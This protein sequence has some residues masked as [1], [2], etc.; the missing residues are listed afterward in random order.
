MVWIQPI[1]VIPLGYHCMALCTCTQL[2]EPMQMLIKLHERAPFCIWRNP[3]D[4]N[5]FF[6]C[7]KLYVCDD[8]GSSRRT[9]R[10][11]R[12]S[13][14][15][16]FWAKRPYNGSGITQHEWNSCCGVEPL[17]CQPW[18]IDALAFFQHSFH[19]FLH[20]LFFT[21]LL[22]SWL[23]FFFLVLLLFMW[24]LQFSCVH[25]KFVLLNMHAWCFVNYLTSISH[26]D[27]AIITSYASA[28]TRVH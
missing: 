27:F 19:F 23:S 6:R 20:C 26:L 12:G 25:L 2:F 9:A 8:I 4:V 21:L 14:L 28:C 22:L 18:C 3:N 1:P 11:M 24:P 5:S 15:P 13:A 17:V 10:T 7:A 16:A